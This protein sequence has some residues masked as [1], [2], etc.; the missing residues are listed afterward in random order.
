MLERTID[1]KKQQIFSSTIPTNHSMYTLMH[2]PQYR[3]S[4]HMAEC[5][6]QPAPHISFY[7]GEV[8]LIAPKLNIV[9]V[10]PKAFISNR[11]EGTN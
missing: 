4:I 2:D 9:L 6:L 7:L 11:K 10:K 1:N 5:G 3:L 8:Q